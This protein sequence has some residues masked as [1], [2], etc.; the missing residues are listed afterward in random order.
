[1]FKIN[2]QIESNGVKEVKLVSEDGLR[3][4]SLEEA[5][6]IADEADL[7]LVMV[8]EKEVPPICKLMNYEKY[9]YELHKREKSNKKNNRAFKEYKLKY[10]IAKRDIDIKLNNIQKAINNGDKVKVSMIFRGREEKLME[11]GLSTMQ[12]V[13][14]TLKNYKIAKDISKEGNALT[15]ILESNIKGK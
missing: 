4:M 7:D 12:Y 13:K 10:G 2:E 15:V 9:L 5:L 8:G 1:M 6:N 14:D 11:L 3:V